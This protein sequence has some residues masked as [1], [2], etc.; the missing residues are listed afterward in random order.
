MQFLK[1]QKNCVFSRMTGSGS[2]CFGVFLTKKNAH[3]ALLKVRKV[4]VF[5]ASLQKLFKF[6]KL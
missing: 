6:T 4:Q 3:E 1:N 2:A 5:S